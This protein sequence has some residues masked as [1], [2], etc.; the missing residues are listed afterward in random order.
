MNEFGESPFTDEEED[1][2]KELDDYEESELGYY[3][4][5]VEDFKEYIHGIKDAKYVCGQT[6]YYKKKHVERY[7]NR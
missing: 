2:L 5:N 1:E 7:N 4:D 3:V 6:T